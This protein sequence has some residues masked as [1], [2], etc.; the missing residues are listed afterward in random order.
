MFEP[1]DSLLSTLTFLERAV[2]L[3][4]DMY[5]HLTHLRR[6]LANYLNALKRLLWINF[7]DK[8]WGNLECKSM[9]LVN[10]GLRSD[11]A[12]RMREI[13]HIFRRTVMYG[14]C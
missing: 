3:D 2:A 14:G 5:I 12:G 11:G 9:V 1:P 4:G 13:N 10:S 7:Y 6:R 8:T